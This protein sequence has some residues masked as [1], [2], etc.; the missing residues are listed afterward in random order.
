MPG[1]WPPIK[2]FPRQCFSNVFLSQEVLLGHL[3]E[4]DRKKGLRG[5]DT[6]SLT[7]ARVDQSPQG[8]CVWGCG[9]GNHLLIEYFSYQGDPKAS[10]GEE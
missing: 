10:S 7:L 3:G 6:T 5:W 2:K 4:R 8:N 1:F 9:G